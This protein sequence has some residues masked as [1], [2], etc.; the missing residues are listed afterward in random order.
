ML[1]MERLRSELEMGHQ[2]YLRSVMFAAACSQ[3]QFPA[4]QT[5]MV[6]L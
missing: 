6:L 3:V 4:M 1:A 5:G 2:T